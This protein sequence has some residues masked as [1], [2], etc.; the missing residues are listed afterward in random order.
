M[1]WLTAPIPT[2]THPVTMFA[3]SI[4]NPKTIAIAGKDLASI[5]MFVAF[6]ILR[7]P[8]EKISSNSKE[9]SFYTITQYY[10]HT[11][12]LFGWSA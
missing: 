7:P 11:N 4:R 6:L 2:K 8:K 1:P 12:I 5:F 9:E 3:T 10:R